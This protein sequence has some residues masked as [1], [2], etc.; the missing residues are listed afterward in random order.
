MDMISDFDTLDVMVGSDIINPIERKLASAIEES[1]VQYDTQSNLP[2][3][4][5]FPQENEF[6]N[7]NY[8]NIIPRHEDKLE[9]LKTFTNGV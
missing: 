1:S 6:S 9:S 3:R 5:N 4:E 7:Q 2:A 8:G